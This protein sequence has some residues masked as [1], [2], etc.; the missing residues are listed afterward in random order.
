MLFFICKNYNSFK[1]FADDVLTGKY[2]YM[3]FSSGEDSGYEPLYVERIGENT[4]AMAHT[5]VQNGDLMY[6]PEMT[7]SFDNEKE[8]L[9]PLTYEHS[10]MGLYQEVQQYHLH[11]FQ[12]PDLRP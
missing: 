5:F 7:F 4:I 3:R 11:Q 1:K 12:S 10:P 8:E 6:D 2:T 9:L